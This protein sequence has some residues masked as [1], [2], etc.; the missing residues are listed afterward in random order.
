MKERHSRRHTGERNYVCHVCGVALTNPHGLKLHMKIH[1]DRPYKCEFCGFAFISNFKYARHV[2]TNIR[3][4]IP[5]YKILRKLAAEAAEREKEPEERPEVEQM[6][7]L[8]V[9]LERKEL[10]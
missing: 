5:H 2:K 1:E 3:P 10:K 4:K 7:V 6:P 9:D 8:G